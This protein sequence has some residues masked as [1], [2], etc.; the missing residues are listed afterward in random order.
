[1]TEAE[2]L[3]RE[4]VVIRNYIEAVRP[5]DV[6]HDDTWGPLLAF[7]DNLITVPHSPE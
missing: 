6:P 3:R 4:L 5:K 1:M 2:Y 7:I